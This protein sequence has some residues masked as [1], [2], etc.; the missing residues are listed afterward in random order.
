MKLEVVN[1]LGCGDLEHYLG[2]VFEATA[3]KGQK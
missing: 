3:L 2:T 1:L